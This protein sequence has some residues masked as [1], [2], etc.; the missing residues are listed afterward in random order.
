M[1]KLTNCTVNIY[2]EKPW[3]INK[4][5]LK[6][7]VRCEVCET[8]SIIKG[9]KIQERMHWH[10]K[11][12]CD[13]EFEIFG[14]L[15]KSEGKI[16]PICKHEVINIEDRSFESGYWKVSNGIDCHFATRERIDHNL[17]L[18]KHIQIEVFQH[19]GGSRTKYSTWSM[20]SE[21]DFCIVS[22]LLPCILFQLHS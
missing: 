19:M 10:S 8:Y 3:I 11:H 7:L 14:K 21:A 20:D 17:I 4:T 13:Q 16:C 12:H 22:E 9:N 2:A 15:M 6:T 18:L 5:P 1:G